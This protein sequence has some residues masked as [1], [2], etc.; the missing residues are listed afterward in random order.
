M[1]EDEAQIAKFLSDYGLAAEQFPKAEV[2]ATKTPDFRVRGVE[3]GGHLFYCEVKSIQRDSWLDRK[4]EKAKP[5]E[6]VGGAR[7]D[8]IFNRLTDDIH[9]A[10]KQFAA[11]NALVEHPNVLAFVNHD[12]MCG[13]LDLIAV[14]TGNFM[15]EGGKA[16]PTYRIY[17]EGRVKGDKANIHLFLWVDD[18]KPARL[19]FAQNHE[20]HHLLLCS[21]FQMDPEAIV[22]INS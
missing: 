20:Q 6:L 12:R 17:S 21:C 1:D 4:L 15:A 3:T 16:L 11:V 2:G 18:F 13:F 8:P 10:A 9:K 7:K 5:G 22:P 19:L 14:L